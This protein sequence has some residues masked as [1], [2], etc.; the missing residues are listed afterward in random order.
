MTVSL[1]GT[2]EVRDNAQIF[3]LTGLLDAFSEP[4]F[5]KTV[6]SYIDQG[7]KHIILDLSKIDF[8]DSSG[9]GA[10]VQLVK[11]ATEDREKKGSLQVIANARVLQTVKLVRLE[12]FLSVR[13]TLEVALDNLKSS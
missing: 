9:L 2:R 13:E 12:S 5:R 11:K 3:R 8:V 7:P 1:R 10:L 6:S 4:T